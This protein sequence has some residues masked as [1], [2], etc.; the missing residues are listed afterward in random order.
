MTELQGVNEDE[1]GLARLALNKL[2]MLVDGFLSVAL[3]SLALPDP[4]SFIAG[5]NKVINAFVEVVAATGASPA[6]EFARQLR[7]MAGKLS[8]LTE[9]FYIRLLTVSDWRSLEESELDASFLALA[10]T[11]SELSNLF[12][13][14]LQLFEGDHCLEKG[15]EKSLVLIEMAREDFKGRNR[16]ANG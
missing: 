11:Y 12:E 10:V 5:R 8:S 1:I 9:L 16:G 13:G 4:K 15:R 14:L 6:S 7:E 2:I 3:A